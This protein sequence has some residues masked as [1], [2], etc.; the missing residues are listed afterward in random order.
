[1][2]TNKR[3]QELRKG[4][5]IYIFVQDNIGVETVQET[6]WRDVCDFTAAITQGR[7]QRIFYVITNRGEHPMYFGEQTGTVYTANCFGSKFGTYLMSTNLQDLENYIV[8]RKRDE[9][10]QQKQ[11]NIAARERIKSYEDQ[12]ENFKIALKTYE[13]LY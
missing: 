5:K 1:M 7:T 9:L 10:E 3:F 12:L 4:D 6:G 2:N 8:K 13:K 11:Y